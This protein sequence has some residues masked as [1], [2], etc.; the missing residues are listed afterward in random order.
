[1]GR[2]MTESI[3]TRPQPETEGF[4]RDQR[5]AIMVMG[6]FLA[7]SMIA[8][9]WYMMGV[10][11]AILWRDHQQEA[12]D[13]IA[14][15][16]AAIHAR[17]MNFIAMVNIIMMF[18]IA[19]YLIAC[20][21]RTILDMVL[22]IT[23]DPTSIT[24]E[25]FFDL[26]NTKGHAA[27]NAVDTIVGFVTNGDSV[28]R[29]YGSGNHP[30]GS[31]GGLL[32]T[33]GDVTG[34]LIDNAAGRDYIINADC[35]IAIILCCIADHPMEEIANPVSSLYVM[36]E[37]FIVFYEKTIMRNV[38]PLMHG[39]EVLTGLLS[40]WIGAGLGIYAGYQYKDG[41]NQEPTNKIAHKGIAISPS[42]FRKLKKPKEVKELN[43][44]DD[45][46]IP[47]ANKAGCGNGC[48]PT[49]CASDGMVSR[50]GPRKSG[51]GGVDA[52]C[53]A[54]AT[55]P[56]CTNAGTCNGHGG[57]AAN[58][59]SIYKTVTIDDSKDY[60]IGLPVE[61][62]NMQQLC[63]KAFTYLG[64]GISNM[65][66]GLPGMGASFGGKSASSMITGLFEKAGGWFMKAY[67]SYDPAF[68]AGH[69]KD[70]YEDV[71]PKNGSYK[72]GC[73]G[74]CSGS[75]PGDANDFWAINDTDDCPFGWTHPGLPIL[76]SG[77][78]GGG[79]GPM[80]VVAYAPNGG[81][82]DQ[83][84][85]IVINDNYNPTKGE[86]GTA[87]SQTNWSKIRLGVGPAQWAN[88]NDTSGLVSDGDPLAYVVGGNGNGPW[89][90]IAEAEFYH[91]C[92]ANWDDNSC[93]G[94]D[95][96]TYRL[97]WRTRLRRTHRPIYITDLIGK[98]IPSFIG[99]AGNWLSS[100]S[101]VGTKLVSD[102]TGGGV[103]LTGV[104]NLVETLTQIAGSNEDGLMPPIYH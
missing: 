17:G 83:I 77:Q 104:F 72:G 44:P 30:C 61:A 84:Y 64:E 47:C 56:G 45:K 99:K 101:W 42:M 76:W 96:A 63:Q 60:R 20:I 67:C 97:N 94:G 52:E 46:W 54:K 35:T 33:L 32:G 24:C 89:F 31:D 1:M 28:P 11:D 15:T 82:Y 75:C 22:Y 55:D 49:V 103:D 65:M 86:Y 19:V 102:L 53:C 79:N 4:V 95:H 18:I 2:T 57:P 14:F 9:M 43:V 50:S 51:T 26:K 100:N 91:D 36:V 3:S 29:Y 73:S 93:N 98:N 38:M 70:G 78:H 87:N 68:G 39:A 48:G 74:V 81:D 66:S 37:K 85:G 12:A 16:S 6:I 88:A 25:P 5:G 58:N 41:P 27:L 40:P 34:D 8:A 69:S 62:E 13:S 7:C 23:G 71:F 90:Y 59:D 92:D 21:I 10:G 80:K